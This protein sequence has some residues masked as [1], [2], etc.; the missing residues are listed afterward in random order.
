MLTLPLPPQEFIGNE[1]IAALLDAP[2][3][4]SS[5]PEFYGTDMSVIEN[6]SNAKSVPMEFFMTGFA[7]EESYSELTSE[8]IE[9]K[10]AMYDVRKELYNLVKET[11][12]EGDDTSVTKFIEDLYEES[13]YDFGIY[14]EQL[15]RIYLSF[16]KKSEFRYANRVLLVLLSFDKE[17][18]G[19]Y[20]YYIPCAAL[21][22]ENLNIQSTALSMIGKWKVIDLRDQVNAYNVPNDN[23]IRLKYKKVKKL[24]DAIH[25][26]G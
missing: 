7:K 11:D 22:V 2:A 17:Q 14:I 13:D 20:S 3:I 25:T 1:E 24:L 6:M 12:V 4:Y 23:F 9:Y 5:V 19:D 26:E 8:R 15:K 21:K 18:V 16:I 10:D